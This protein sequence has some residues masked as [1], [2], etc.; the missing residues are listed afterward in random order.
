MAC[1]GPSYLTVFPVVGVDINGNGGPIYVSPLV[2]RSHVLEL[3][4]HTLVIS[5]R[6][7]SFTHLY[8]ARTHIHVVNVRG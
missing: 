7:V 6:E 3:R 4:F 5:G 1:R 2:F 8:S